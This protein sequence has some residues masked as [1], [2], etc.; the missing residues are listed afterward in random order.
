MQGFGEFYGYNC[1]RLAHNY[2]P[3]HLW[4]NQQKI[5]TPEN[6]DGISFLPSLLGKGQPQHNLLYWEFHEPGG[7]Q[8]V[9]KGEWKPVQYNVFDSTQTTTELFNLSSDIGEENDIAGQNPN[10][11]K[12][13]TELIKFSR[14]ESGD[15]V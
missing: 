8:A 11:V 7:R 13:L 9:R 5:E 3:G 2:Y 14:T 12:E 6:I 10:I 4:D 1:Q 15:F